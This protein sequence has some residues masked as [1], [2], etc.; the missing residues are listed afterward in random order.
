MLLQLAR[1][2]PQRDKHRLERVRVAH[3]TENGATRLEAD[4]VVRLHHTARRCAARRP[5]L[6]PGRVRH[7]LHEDVHVRGREPARREPAH[8]REIVGVCEAER[9][10]RGRVLDLHVRDLSAQVSLELPFH[11]LGVLAGRR[12][13]RTGQSADESTTCA[14]V[15][16]R[17]R[18]R[19]LGKHTSERRRVAC[20]AELER[21]QRTARVRA[22]Q[23]SVQPLRVGRREIRGIQASGMRACAPRN[24]RSSAAQT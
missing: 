6:G 16:L 4:A 17:C 8:E 10:E 12:H 1:G 2:I 22:E 3:K 14:G 23:L 5:A 19:S 18:G 9:F 24:L 15:A 20:G 7:F 11:P 13:A 21:L